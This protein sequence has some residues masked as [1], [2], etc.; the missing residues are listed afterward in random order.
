MFESMT[1]P[2]F[3]QYVTLVYDKWNYRKRKIQKNVQSIIWVINI[4]C[5]DIVAEIVY[6]YIFS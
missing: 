4:P 3:I 1:I 6:I 5:S 2:E